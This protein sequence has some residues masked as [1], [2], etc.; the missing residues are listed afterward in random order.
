MFNENK[1]EMRKYNYQVGRNMPK[2][3]QKLKCI[4]DKETSNNPLEYQSRN[5]LLIKTTLQM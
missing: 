5:N 3:Q 4:L 2:F 1:L